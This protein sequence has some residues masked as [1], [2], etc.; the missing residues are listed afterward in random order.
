M[1]ARIFLK[2]ILYQESQRAQKQLRPG[3]TRRVCIH[4][5]RDRTSA[6]R[7]PEDAAGEQVSLAPTRPATAARASRLH[8]HPHLRLGWSSPTGGTCCAWEQVTVAARRTQVRSFGPS[9]FPAARA[10]LRDSRSSSRRDHLGRQQAAPPT[11]DQRPRAT[12]YTTGDAPV[13]EEPPAR[14]AE[15]APG[16]RG[17]SAPRTPDSGFVQI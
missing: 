15:R 9:I 6:P 12:P 5:P 11:R 16:Q 13:V 4:A 7:S 14:S 8:L 17:G 1:E 3:L 10:A 2:C